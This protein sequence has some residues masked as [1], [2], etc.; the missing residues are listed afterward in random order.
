M[1]PALGS[2]LAATQGRTAPSDSSTRSKDGFVSVGSARSSS[3]NNQ[4]SSLPSSHQ[5]ASESAGQLPTCPSGQSPTSPEAQGQPQPESPAQLE[6][7]EVAN[8]GGGSSI[9]QPDTS[10]PFQQ[11]L[12]ALHADQQGKELQAAPSCSS[13]ASA[14]A[15]QEVRSSTQDSKEQAS[16]AESQPQDSEPSQAPAQ[17]PF[18]NA[19][20]G[21]QHGKHA[22][23]SSAAG[24][25][26]G[27]EAGSEAVNAS[28]V[29]SASTD[30][31]EMVQDANNIYN[32]KAGS[33][34]GRSLSSNVRQ[35]SE[36]SEEGESYSQCK[37]LHDVKCLLACSNCRELCCRQIP[38]VSNV[39]SCSS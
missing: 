27:T 3:S 11:S 29:G 32:W 28:P 4:S 22:A 39:S 16:V 20:D 14:V 9:P 30:A 15:K 24:G 26:A 38:D 37:Q 36:C 6:T 7:N 19:T 21:G 25:A 12:D 13:E 17:T 34:F 1:E 10:D 2:S 35:G 33:L 18:S 31:W 5:T 8:T 23:S